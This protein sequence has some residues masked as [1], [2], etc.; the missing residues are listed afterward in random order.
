MTG[1]PEAMANTLTG[2]LFCVFTSASDEG[3]DRPSRQIFV[4]SRADARFLEAEFGNMLAEGCGQSFCTSGDSVYRGTDLPVVEQSAR[5][6]RSKVESMP[7]TWPVVLGYAMGPGSS[8]GEPIHDQ[9]SRQ[10]L[11]EFLTG[12]VQLAVEAQREKR[13]LHWGAASD[14]PTTRRPRS[15]QHD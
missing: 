10:R 2:Y 6:V 14:Q 15:N 12:V 4:R 7:E 1:W 5:D 13:F 3:A 8:I 9:A 11:L